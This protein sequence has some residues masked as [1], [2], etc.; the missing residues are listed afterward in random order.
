V[1]VTFETALAS[2][3][4]ANTLLQKTSAWINSLSPDRRSTLV[5]AVCEKLLSEY[6]LPRHGNP[7]EPL[8]DLIYI[9]LT[10]RSRISAAAAVFDKLKARFKKWSDVLDDP[11]DLIAL[12]KPIGLSMVK[13]AQ[14]LGIV[15]RLSIDFGEV[16]LAS[17]KNRGIDYVYI[18]L[19]SLPGV[20]TKIAKCVMLYTLGFAVLPVD[21]NTYRVASRLGWTTKKRAELCHGE[22]ELLIPPDLRYAFHVDAIMHG[23]LIC[24]PVNPLCDKCIISNECLFKLESRNR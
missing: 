4:A 6:G 5:E 17:I 13:S 7:Q 3:D 18:Y 8:D 11:D 22:L 2:E 23:N 16:S 21:V 15:A 14:I 24:K 1:T 12:I 10:T 20:S 19:T 9:I